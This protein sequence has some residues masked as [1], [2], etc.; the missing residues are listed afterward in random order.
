[1]TQTEFCS[2][3]IYLPVGFPWVRSGVGTVGCGYVRVEF[4]LRS[5][6]GL[7]GNREGGVVFVLSSC[8]SCVFVLFSTIFL[9]LYS[10]LI[11]IIYFSINLEYKA[12]K[13]EEEKMFLICFKNLYFYH[14]YFYFLHLTH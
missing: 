7:V 12:K 4:T 3:G 5:G 2:D 9:I 8:A 11:G 1:M 14:F 13:K 6:Q 10:G